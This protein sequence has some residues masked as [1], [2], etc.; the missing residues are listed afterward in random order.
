[1]PVRRMPAEWEPHAAT[2][3]AW[4]HSRETW[5]SCMPEAEA[6]FEGLVRALAQSEQVQV[7]VRD[8]DLRGEVRARLGELAAS[9]RVHLHTVATDDAWLRD[10][11]PTFVHDAESGLVALDWT[12]DSW[13]GKYPPWDRDAAVAE[14]IAALAGATHRRVDLVVEGGALE[15]DGAGTLLASAALADAR[16]NPGIERADVERVLQDLL[17]TERILWID[18]AI[19]GDDT[20]GHI[21]QIARFTAPGRAVC[22]RAL[23]RDHH[24][25]EPFEYCRQRLLEADLDVVDLPMPPPLEVDGAELPA[26]Y[27]NFYIAN[28]AVLVPRFG[29]PTDVDALD[30]LA[31]LFPTRKVLGVPSRT[32]L[33]GL[34]SLHCLTQQ[35][36]E[37]QPQ[38]QQ[39]Q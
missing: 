39:Q 10:T 4:P 5:P 7:L 32:L 38:Q 15:T 36:P 22:T 28:A 31:R 2:W 35:Q 9:G 30:L 1:M 19:P 12:F 29:V 3:V 13:G 24:D 18:G 14:R 11:G 26:S 25:R 16:R 34:G 8:D 17:G 33:H 37:S 27:A 20:D 23:D 6:E 21:D